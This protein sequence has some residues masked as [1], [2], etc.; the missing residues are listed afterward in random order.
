MR[1]LDGA[2]RQA[3][4]TGLLLLLVELALVLQLVLIQLLLLHLLG[5]RGGRQTPPATRGAAAASVR[6][7]VE[8]AG[9]R[10]LVIVLERSRH[11]VISWGQL[12]Q[13]V[14]VGGGSVA[15][16]MR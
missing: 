6:V 16:M 5:R 4:R 14:V 3:A 12:V 10:V 15:G 1:W 11:V 8:V 9:V 7:S 13:K 2:G